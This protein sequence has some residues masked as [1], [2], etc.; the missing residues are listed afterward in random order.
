MV[1]LSLLP[2]LHNHW[3]NHPNLWVWNHC[4]W[5]KDTPR[6]S[7]TDL[8]T[9]ISFTNRKVHWAMEINLPLPLPQLFLASQRGRLPLQGNSAIHVTGVS[10]QNVLSI[11]PPLGESLLPVGAL[12]SLSINA[13]S[14]I[15]PDSLQTL[16]L[17]KRK[18]QSQLKGSART[19]SF[20]TM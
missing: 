8:V 13:H 6:P 12:M 2:L 15:P 3:L 11:F 16:S 7:K 18:V 4:R 14:E 19:V 1:P 9:C 5:N 10:G 17:L 20:Q